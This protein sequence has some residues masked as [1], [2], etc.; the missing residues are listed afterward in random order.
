VAVLDRGSGRAEAAIAAREAPEKDAG[1]SID[2]VLRHFL[3][4]GVA[5]CI[6]LGPGAPLID[7]CRAAVRGGLTVLEV[8]L[9]TPGA[10]EAMAVLAR[11][12]GTLVGG[13]TVLTPEDA[14][15]V[16]RAGGRFTLS[17]VFAPD[18]IDEATRLGMLAIPGAATPTEILRA[19]HH[20]VRLVKVF[21]SA[22]LGGPTFLRAVRGPFPGVALLPTNGPN[23]ENLADYFDAGAAAVGI[24]ADVFP[25]GFTPAS[26]ESGARKVRQA[27]AA[28]RS[29]TRRP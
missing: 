3:D 9:T 2:Q 6:R 14:R 16:H 27:V 5:L 1:G 7:L 12:A 13:G 29:R 19:H 26:V 21:P 28:W 17:P 15:A 24:M 11:D 22:V 20:G 23:A 4:D 8:T 25:P 18:A 10:L